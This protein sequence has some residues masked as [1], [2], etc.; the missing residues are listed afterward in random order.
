MYSVLVCAVR[1]C[2][3]TRQSLTS[4]SS[5]ATKATTTNYLSDQYLSMEIEFSLNNTKNPI[6]YCC[7][8]QVCDMVDLILASY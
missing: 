5:Y 8:P 3:V 2:T 4:D 1:V 6:V 7:R